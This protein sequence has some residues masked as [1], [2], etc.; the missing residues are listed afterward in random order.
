VW[1]GIVDLQSVSSNRKSSFA[2]PG[3]GFLTT[4]VNE[5]IESDSGNPYNEPA[6]IDLTFRVGTRAMNGKT[7][8]AIGEI[9]VAESGG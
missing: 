3:L 8:H 5:M 9:A 2:F 1:L 6:E 4:R 7:N